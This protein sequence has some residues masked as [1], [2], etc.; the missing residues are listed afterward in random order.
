MTSG[1]APLIEQVKAYS[2]PFGQGAARGVVG[3][4]TTQRGEMRSGPDARWVAFTAEEYVDA[5]KS[6]FCWHAKWGSGLL[7]TDVTDAYQNGHGRLVVKKGPLTLRE[8]TGPE[9][10]KGEL[11]RYL[12]YPIYFPPM[13][14][15]NASLEFTPIGPNTLRV[16]DK[17]DSTGATVDIDVG[18]AG[19]I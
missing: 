7:S 5:T 14:I 18:D 12:A 9:T 15:H 4:K 19:N 10:D 1:A 11:Q 16:S 17:S 6:D 3:I 8:L 2:F 13:M